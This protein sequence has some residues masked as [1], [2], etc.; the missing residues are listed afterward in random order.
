MINIVTKLCSM[1]I[2]A[3]TTYK[4]TDISH[5]RVFNVVNGAPS[6]EH[7]YSVFICFL[8]LLLCVRA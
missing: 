5:I 1:C 2:T 3:Q 4:Y 8:L 7:E 6:M